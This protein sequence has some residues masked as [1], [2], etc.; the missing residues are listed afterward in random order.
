MTSRKYRI[1]RFMRFYAVIPINKV[2]RMT[3]AIT[4]SL[5]LS[6]QLKSPFALCS[7][8][9]VGRSS[10]VQWTKKGRTR[11]CCWSRL[12]HWHRCP[13]SL[14]A[15]PSLPRWWL[16]LAGTKCQAMLCT[17]ISSQTVSISLS[18]PTVISKFAEQLAIIVC[19]VFFDCRHLP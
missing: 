2:T 11:M 10:M 4:F 1:I 9:V 6:L 18:H 16:S 5:S 3:E 7:Q 13:T 17:L 15:R 19:C 8:T 14:L 12:H